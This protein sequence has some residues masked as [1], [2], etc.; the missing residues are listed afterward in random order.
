MESKKHFPIQDY[1]MQLTEL[2]QQSISQ[3]DPAL[4][5]HQK[6]A[7]S[8][9]FMAESLTR[10]LDEANDKKKIEKALKLF[11]KLEDA[12]GKIEENDT[13]IKLF[14]KNKA[15]EKDELV[16][17]L[18]KRIKAIEKLN[19]KLLEKEFYQ[20]DFNRIANGLRVDFNDKALVRKLQ[21]QMKDELEACFS[22]YSG[23]SNGFTDMETQVHEIRRKLR[24]LSM[25]PRSF[26]GVIIL[27]NDRTKY[28]WE[29]KF[30]P[31]PEAGS[32]FNKVTI[33][34]KLTEHIKFNQKAFH[35]LNFV[36][37]ELGKIKD[38]GIELESL[39][40]AIRKTSGLSGKAAEARA[41]E[42][43]GLK[44]TGPDLLQQAHELLKEYFETH[45]IYKLLV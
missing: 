41:I 30:N 32:S 22:F 17:F 11:K 20:V 39:K 44:V 40:K 13:L 24:W 8:P 18:K 43:L 25:Y 7:R 21:K 29:K 37:A 31:A 9:L 10:V 28:K 3:P 38:K 33:N 27:E 15:I 19:N 1:C 42:Q 35:A 16:Y 23:F 34:K 36:V 45:E 4:F 6:D 5:L 2:F 26:Q 14:A 12:L